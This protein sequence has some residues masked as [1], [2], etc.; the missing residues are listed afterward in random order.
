MTRFTRPQQAAGLLAW[1]AASYLASAIGA[2]ASIDAG[3]FYA[4]LARP[5]WAPP[6]WLFGPVWLL[7]YTLMGIAAWLVWREGGLRAASAALTLFIAQLAVNAA[8]SWLFF[9]WRL[10]LAALID[11]ALLW[12][13]IAVMLAAFW[14]LSRLAAALIVPYLL[15]V[16]FAAVLNHAVWRLNPQLLG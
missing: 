7:L 16:S 6:G 5:D 11:I 4:E 12:L 14:R 2:A 15:W 3:P 10:G 13:L 9:A 1:L 8:W